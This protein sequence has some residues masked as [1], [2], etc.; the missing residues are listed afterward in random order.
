VPTC[1]GRSRGGLPVAE[2]IPAGAAVQIVVTV[3]W[4]RGLPTYPGE[5]PGEGAEPGKG[6]AGS[7]C[8][9]GLLFTP[10]DFSPNYL[11]G[12]HSHAVPAQVDRLILASCRAALSKTAKI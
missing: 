4:G 1:E 6:Q 9:S 2:T 3:G 10:A 12:G 8:W 5:P 7:C 11:L